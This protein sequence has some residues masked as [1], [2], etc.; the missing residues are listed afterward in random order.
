MSPWQKLLE[1]PRGGEHYVQLY[2]ADEAALSKNVGHY[3]WEGRR[4]GE[5]VLLIVTPEHQLLFSRYLERTGAD[6][7]ELLGTNQLVFRDAQQTLAEFMTD[8]RPD[9]GRFEKS[10]RA[11]VRQV[12]PKKDVEGL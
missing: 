9:W 5:G 12:T 4:R 6:L 2:E 10:I 7:A 11:A 1:R 3:L 8:G